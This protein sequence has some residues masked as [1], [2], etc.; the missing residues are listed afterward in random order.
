MKLQARAPAHCRSS[1]DRPYR[2][3]S[4]KPPPPLTRSALVM[5]GLDSGIHAVSLRRVEA[6]GNGLPG[7]ARQRRGSWIASFE[8][9]KATA[10]RR[11]QARQ[12][13]LVVEERAEL[14]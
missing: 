11:P 8:V 12:V 4:E 13:N 9:P 3:Y 5:P 6:Q 14:A 10:K 2:R 1:A 7:Q